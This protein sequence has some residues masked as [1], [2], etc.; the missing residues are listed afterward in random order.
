MNT[1]NNDHASQQARQFGSLL[2]QLAARQSPARPGANIPPLGRSPSRLSD[3]LARYL[4]T[5]RARQVAMDKL[6]A[7][8]FIMNG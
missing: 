5:S 7:P 3:L 2:G 1:F 8:E 4:H 6:K